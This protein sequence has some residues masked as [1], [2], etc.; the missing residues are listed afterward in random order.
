MRED[1]A[2]ALDRAGAAVDCGLHHPGPGTSGRRAGADLSRRRPRDPETSVSA[3]SQ[4]RPGRPRVVSASV[5]RRRDAVPGRPLP[6]GETTGLEVR[7]CRRGEE[8]GL[9][10]TSIG[11]QPDEIEE[12]VTRV[13]RPAVRPG[14]GAPPR[15]RGGHRGPGAPRANAPRQSAEESDAAVAI[16]WRRKQAFPFPSCPQTARQSH[17]GRCPFA[18][19]RLSA[20]TRV[21]ACIGA[22]RRPLARVVILKSVR[23]NDIG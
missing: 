9:A 16:G 10:A 11:V 8:V 19:M 7:L 21:D 17:S 18:R 14:P 2:E 20:T 22:R 12:F 15:V 3:N 1:D 5:L 6:R 23:R 13:G 4:Q